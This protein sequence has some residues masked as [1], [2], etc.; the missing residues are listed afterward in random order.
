MPAKNTVRRYD[1]P[2]YYHVYNRGAGGQYIF[3][4]ASDK[5]KFLSL[6]E[7]Y[8]SEDTAH[9]RYPTYEIELIAYCVMGNH[10]H[11]LVF[12]EVNTMALTD[13]MRSVSTAY[14]MYF[15]FKY[16]SHGHVF[17]S[18]YKS[19]MID[20]ESY[21]AHITRYIHLN[22]ETYLTYKYSSLANYIHDR[23][24]TWV[25]PERLLDMTPQRYLNFLEDYRDRRQ[26]LKDI[27][28]EL[29]I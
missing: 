28:A 24:D 29:A 11:M 10:F 2:A 16:K 26:L 22:P 27:K 5:R 23:S 18:V 3:R 20:D 7:R 25:H 15:N 21:L 13:L 9:E 14:S 12:Q 8:L 1:A 19:S 17:Q 6:L 4:D